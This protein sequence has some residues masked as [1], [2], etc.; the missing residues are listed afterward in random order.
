MVTGREDLLQALIEA[1][2]M[3]KGTQEFYSRAAARTSNPRQK[4]MFL[5]LTGWEQDHKDYIQFLYQS[6]EGDADLRGF[7]DFSSKAHAPL[8]EG[9]IP[10][11]NLQEKAENLEFSS[12][13]EAMN[14]ALEIEGRAYNLYR[15]LS[16]TAADPNARVVFREMMEQEQ[17]HVTYLKELKA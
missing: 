8:A 2:L 7:E 10:I 12:D 4:E 9:G 14:L 3:E 13:E 6:V 17:K 15:R 1:F 5:R 16:E 11:K